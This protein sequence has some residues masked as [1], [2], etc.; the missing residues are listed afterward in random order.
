[1]LSTV[2][3]Y[4][5]QE[6][7]LKDGKPLFVVIRLSG[8]QNDFNDVLKERKGLGLPASSSV[9]LLDVPLLSEFVEN[10]V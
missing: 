3:D 8:V 2:L 1:M 5:A 4:L 10:N 7:A 9:S 6:I